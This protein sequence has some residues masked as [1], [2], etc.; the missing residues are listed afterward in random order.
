MYV[1]GF[2]Q[3]ATQAEEERAEEKDNVDPLF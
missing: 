3:M 2:W 1:Y